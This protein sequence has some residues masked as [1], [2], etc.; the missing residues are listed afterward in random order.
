MMFSLAALPMRLTIHSSSCVQP[1]PS[2]DL[3]HNTKSCH[4]AQRPTLSSSL[5]L[6]YKPSAEQSSTM[7][8]LKAISP[9]L[10]PSLRNLAHGRPTNGL[11]HNGMNT[12]P[13][14]ACLGQEKTITRTHLLGL[15]NPCPL[16]SPELAGTLTLS[17]PLSFTTSHCPSPLSHQSAL[18]SSHLASGAVAPTLESE[19]GTVDMVPTSTSRET[20]DEP[21]GTGGS[22]GSAVGREAGA[23]GEGV[24]E[25][26]VALKEES[27]GATGGGAPSYQEAIQRLQTYWAEAGCAILQPSNTEV[28]AGT[29]NP[30]TF[31]RVLGPEPWKV[32]YVE[33]SV[34]PDDS[35]YGENPNRVQKHTQFQVILK[36]DPGCAQEL[37]LGSLACLGIDTRKHDVRFVED[38]WESPVLGAWGLG[39]E[40]WLDGME[41][42]QFTYFQQA[43]SMPVT[44]VSVEIT[45]GLERIIMSLQGVDHFKDIV[46]APGVT[47]GE[48]FLENEREMS[49][50][51]LEHADVERTQ[52]RF[53]LYDAE[54][55]ALLERGLAIPAYDH[56]LKT[57]HAFNI[58]DARGAVG[59]T[60]RARFFARMRNLA[61][62]CAVLWVETRERLGHPLG[63]W[64]EAAAPFLPQ[65]EPQLAETSPPRD[66]VLEIGSEEL[67][68]DDVRSGIAQLEAAVPALLQRLRLPHGAISVSGTPRRLAVMVAALGVRQED[69]SAEVRGPPKTKAFDSEGKLTKALEGFCK[70]NKVSSADI[71]MKSDEKGTDYAYATVTAIG[72]PTAEVLGTELAALVSSLSFPKTMRWNSQV[73]FSR[74]LRWLLALHGEALI[75]F[76]YA[77]MVSSQTS[78]LLRNAAEPKR[79]VARA[80][81][82]ASV[83][84]AGGITLSQEAREEAIWS[85]SSALASS[86]GGRI[87]EEARGVLLAEVANLVEAPFPLLGHFDE[88][89]LALPR[90]VLITVMKKHQRYFP[91]EDATSG[92]L[93]AAFVAVPNGPLDEAA[94]RRGN[95][96]VLRARYA[97]ARFFYEADTSRPLG[98]FREQL[99]GITFQEKL[100]S[101][102]AKSQRIEAALPELAALLS[103][104]DDARSLA[105]QAAPLA[106]ADLATA[107]VMEFTALAGVMGRHYAER[108]GQPPEVAEAVLE[109]VL[110]R[111]AGDRFPCSDPG[112]LLAVAD[113]LDSLVG[114]FAVG[115]EPSASADPFGL[116]R[117]AYALVQA[118]V[119]NDKGLD[120]RVAFAV[121]AKGQPVP[122]TDEVLQQT[123]TFVVRR[124][125]Q[126]LVDGGATVELVRAV[127][128]ERGSFP[129][130]ASRSVRQMEAVSSRGQLAPLVAAYARPTRIAR[131]KDIDA[132][133]QVDESKFEGPKERKL[134]EAYQEA[135]AALTP[136]ADIE[137]FVAASQP[138]LGALDDFFTNVFVMAEDASLRQ[139]RLALL[140]DVALLP[141][142][143]VD[144]SLLPGF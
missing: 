128:A 120:L 100:G 33:P 8:R 1:Q 7:L 76:V 52:Q 111:F 106:M 54:A 89:F 101:M 94:V 6:S 124:L 16:L 61:R 109:S 30:A 71:Y 9:L 139:N 26:I 50:F 29:M 107:M 53:E 12:S 25:G 78:R 66:F 83:L 144:L 81:D 114:L 77:G 90:E 67:P 97:D 73:A 20:S 45:Y 141:R 64:E 39:W 91:I 86:I 130:L 119:E 46:Y 133:W 135:R 68:P 22:S 136:G 85:A 115:C 42:S 62:Q 69:S 84:E 44:P 14:F 104:S 10:K 134:W 79:E 98:S 34:R 43:G 142:G 18:K 41:I 17:S 5:N 37:Y 82:Y 74:P 2:C 35:R 48:L 49:G 21:N 143:I 118:L 60:E 19:P 51:N 110:P 87:P 125:E 63:V 4:K 129:A 31:L 92:K 122:V 117:S 80:E 96:A 58:L 38:N 3:S 116:R 28:G 11:R 113:R 138:L 32:A 70:K 131:G 36:P 88:S 56:V 126:L 40:V 55:R 13:L 24:E 27:D 132:S 59:V 65:G 127:L 137:A 57:S 99:R 75:P 123:L 121:V 140:R 105:M 108:E 93:L 47:Y 72:R 23:P 95:E 112:V 102:L 15:R 103:L